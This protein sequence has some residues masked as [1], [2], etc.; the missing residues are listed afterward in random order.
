M[1]HNTFTPFALHHIPFGVNE[2]GPGVKVTVCTTLYI[3]I[4]HML[5][6]IRFRLAVG[7]EYFGAAKYYRLVGI[8]RY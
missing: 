4:Y 1:T 3:Y 8:E 6:R 7:V 2:P 5:V